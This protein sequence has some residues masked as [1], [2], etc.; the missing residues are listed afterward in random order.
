MGQINRL[1]TYRERNLLVK[2][3]KAYA[4]IWIWYMVVYAK[5]WIGSEDHL[6]DDCQANWKELDE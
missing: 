5:I 4:Y 6:F 3:V 2:L 1:D